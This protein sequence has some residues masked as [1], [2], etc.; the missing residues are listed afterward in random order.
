M[1]YKI[2]GDTLKNGRVTR[3][4]MTESY[5]DALSLFDDFVDEL[6]GVWKPL[7]TNSDEMP[8]E[9]TFDQL[10]SGDFGGYH[11]FSDD[12]LGGWHFFLKSGW[13]YSGDAADEVGQRCSAMQKLDPHMF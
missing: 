10:L 7:N 3:K 6:D 9:L 1:I 13:V 11:N 5:P 2:T 12:A 4:L 8:L